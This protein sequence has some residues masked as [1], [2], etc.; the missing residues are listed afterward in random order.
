MTDLNPT[1]TQENIVSDTDDR[2]VRLDR[3]G[4]RLMADADN[5]SF[6]RG[7]GLRQGVRSDLVTGRDWARERVGR[8]RTRIVDTPVKASAYALGLGVL[9]GL[10]LRR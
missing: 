3:E 5:R 8:A 1:L 6:A 7:A 9:I 2:R 10:L 4:D